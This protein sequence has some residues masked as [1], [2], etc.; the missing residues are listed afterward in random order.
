MRKLS[1]VLLLLCFPFFMRS[2]NAIT[3]KVVDELGLPVYLASVSIN[4]SDTVVHTDFDGNFTLE[5]TKDFHWKITITSAGYTTES[6]FVLDG[7]KTEDL[8]LKYDIALQELLN[9][10]TEEDDGS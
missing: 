4:G 1:I 2:Q 7:G 9:G 10:D 6:F 3:G 8:V 5:S